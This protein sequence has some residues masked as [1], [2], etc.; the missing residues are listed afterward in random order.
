[1]SLA[2]GIDRAR[3]RN[4]RRAEQRQ[5]PVDGI[6]RHAD[7]LERE[8][9]GVEQ[10]LKIARPAAE[11]PRERVEHLVERDRARRAAAELQVR[12]LL[13][14]LASDR[15]RVLQARRVDRLM[16]RAC[17]VVGAAVRAQRDLRAGEAAARRIEAR[18][19]DAR[20]RRRVARQIGAAEVQSVERDVVLVGAE[21]EHGEA[22]R[23]AV[24]AGNERHA[25]ERRGHGRQ[26]AEHVDR[27]VV[28]VERLVASAD[29]DLIAV[30][31]RAALGPRSRAPRRATRPSC[32]CVASA[33]RISSSTS[34]FT[35]KRV[36]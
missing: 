1:M 21:S 27:N 32:P 23:A 33:T 36:G 35:S 34:R 4:V 19:R 15:V 30:A 3:E 12:E 17:S 8:R 16:Q 9:V 7:A 29:F 24:G 13:A 26:V 5:E 25:R 18:R 31:V 11:L 2:F 14:E 20:L 10:I 22:G 6:R 28:R